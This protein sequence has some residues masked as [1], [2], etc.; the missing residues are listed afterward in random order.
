MPGLVRRR[1]RLAEDEGDGAAM[2]VGAYLPGM[3]KGGRGKTGRAV[4]RFRPS[5]RLAQRAIATKTA[6]RANFVAMGRWPISIYL[7]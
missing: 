5:P 4:C 7:I 2:G 1:A 3:G 6:L